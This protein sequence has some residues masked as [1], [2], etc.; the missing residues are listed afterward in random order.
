[1]GDREDFSSERSDLTAIFLEDHSP[2]LQIEVPP[3]IETKAD[4]LLVR[5]AVLAALLKILP[6]YFCSFL[7]HALLIVGLSVAASMAC[8]GER[9]ALDGGMVTVG[10]AEQLEPLEVALDL[11][12]PSSEMQKLQE[13]E[14]E[15]AATLADAIASSGLFAGKDLLEDW[16]K[17]DDESELDTLVAAGL[18]ESLGSNQAG[19][20]DKG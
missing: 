2:E 12:A 13:Q 8:R 15:S 19:R 20:Q 5:G 3:R 1:M 16:G 14:Q 17:E 7:G 6:S 10:P 11:G 4:E 18:E 9:I